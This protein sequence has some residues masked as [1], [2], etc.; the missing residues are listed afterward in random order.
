MKIQLFIT[1]LNDALF[2]RTGIATTEILERLGH[3]VEFDP[4]QTC[5]GQMHLNSGYTD[6]AVKLAER[7]LDIYESAECIVS[8]SGSCVANVREMFAHAGRWTHNSSLVDRA[9]KM[10]GK[11]FE[12]SEFLLEFGGMETL[13]PYFPH[14]VT[15]HPTCHGARALRLMD[16]PEKLLRQVRGLELVELSEK[17]QCCGF[18][19]TFSVKNPETS[20]AMLND[21]CA[22]ICAL[23]VE[24][25]V[26]ID[27]SCLM[28]IGGGL[29]KDGRTP[30]V[31]HLAEVLA[32]RGQ[33]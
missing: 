27:N 2:P 33:A 3:T 32:S 21:K 28:H 17:W 1:C 9:A 15:Y 25:C 22:A 19:G 18:G 7:W 14:K 13:A 24:Y 5:C 12:L 20:S 4:R 30:K 29:R 8:P 6:E 23:E 31:I 16:S 26:A 10:E 11:L